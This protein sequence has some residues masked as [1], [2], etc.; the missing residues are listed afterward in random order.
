MIRWCAYC[1]TYLGESEPYENF[2]LTHG[3]CES[4]TV[5]GVHKDASEVARLRPLAVFFSQLRAEVRAGIT[6]D[7]ADWVRKALALGIKPAD[8]LL[9]MLQPALYEIGDQW[10]KGEATVATEHAFSA[11]AEKAY[12]AVFAQYPELAGNSQA[13]APDILLANVDGNYHTLGIKFLEIALLAEGLKTFTVLPGLP[14]P[15]VL[16]L[17]KTLA[18]GA[19]GLSVSMPEHLKAAEGI[20]AELLKLPEG[21]RPL[22]L[23]GGGIVKKARVLP[24]ALEA[25]VCGSILDIPLDLLR[26]KRKA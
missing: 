3:L 5:K 25:H 16:A 12:A 14:G 11:F 23:L 15:E 21:D 8:L 20:A 1:Q 19:L 7:P 10:A 2:S 9:G 24:K 18:P 22:L 4:C 13:K 6:S 26:S 17:V